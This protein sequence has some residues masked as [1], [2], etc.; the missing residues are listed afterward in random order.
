[1]NPKIKDLATKILAAL[2]RGAE[3]A[4]R[5]VEN[6]ATDAALLEVLKANL[7]TRAKEAGHDMTALATLC[8]KALDAC[9]AGKMD[10]C[11]GYLETCIEVMSA[12]APGAALA[13]LLDHYPAAAE[14]YENLQYAHAGLCRSGLDAAMAAELRAKEA[15][16]RAM[17]GPARRAL[18]AANGQ[19]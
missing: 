13:R 9:T 3:S 16:D 7:A 8:Q 11:V 5:A 2:L 14:V 19:A 10:E 17:G 18:D 6:V 12:M 15:I 1:M 4:G